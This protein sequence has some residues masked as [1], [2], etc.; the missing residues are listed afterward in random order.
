MKRYFGIYKIL[1]RLNFSALIVYRANFIS[2]VIAS[3]SWGVLMIASIAL[4]TSKAKSINGWTRDELLILS[5]AYSIVITLFHMFF[6]RNFERFSQVINRGE[7]DGILLKP[8][9]SQFLMSFW[10]FH[11]PNS[12]RLL[13]GI[14]FIT[15]MIFKTGLTVS[16]INVIG[17]AALAIFSITLLYSIWFI[18]ST[19][20]IWFTTL[21]NLTDFLYNFTSFGRFP[22]EVYQ[23][24]KVY[25]FAFLLPLSLVVATPTKALI[26]KAL[27]GDIAM[28]LAFSVIFFLLSG[29]FWKFAL[30]YYTSAN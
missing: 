21:T 23:E 20:T 11:F 16:L 25:V 22:R 28:L 14:L 17:F 1:L 12:G 4:L 5:G 3:T 27:A 15:Y 9:S 18:T 6:S 24:L 7:L 19:L 2:S 13:M 26:G 8:A 10:L 30:R 29:A